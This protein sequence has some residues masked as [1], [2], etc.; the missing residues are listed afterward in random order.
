MR[1][2]LSTI[3]EVPADR[4]WSA[5]GQSRL[6]EYVAHPLQVFEPLDPPALPQNR[7]FPES[8][9]VWREKDD[10]EPRARVAARQQTPLI[11][12]EMGRTVDG[13]RGRAQALRL[14]LTPSGHPWRTNAR[15]A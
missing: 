11:A 4:A 9:R 7:W 8:P 2:K 12:R 1:I 10:A 15:R 14:T 3:L 6:L 5:V 13:I